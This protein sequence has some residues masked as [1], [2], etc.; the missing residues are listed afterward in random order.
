MSRGGAIREIPVQRD[1]DLMSE[2]DNTRSL[3]IYSDQ[4]KGYISLLDSLLTKTTR[5][6]KYTIRGY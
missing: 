2:L 1:K 5:G 6:L 4:I 3:T